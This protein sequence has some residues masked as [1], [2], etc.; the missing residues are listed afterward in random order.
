MMSGTLH[1]RSEVELHASET[2][3]GRLS[4][5]VMTYGEQVADHRGHVF[6]PGSLEWS[7]DGILLNLSH[8]PKQPLVRTT[9]IAEGDVVRLD[10]DL[11]DTVRGRDASLMIRNGTYRGLSAE[12]VV[13]RDSRANG[14]RE[15][16]AAELVGIGLVTS[17]A[18]KGSTVAVHGEQRRGRRR[19]WL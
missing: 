15:I 6:L 1:L 14:R 11:P 19:V 3:P 5:I 2:G 18:F 13:S 7:D 4:G 17:P 9:P 10:V 8:D 16:H 12:V